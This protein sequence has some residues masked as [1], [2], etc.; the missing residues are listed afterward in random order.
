MQDYMQGD[1]HYLKYIY[2]KNQH[3]AE[4]SAYFLQYQ[5]ST[6]LTLITQIWDNVF[7]QKMSCR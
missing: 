7:H 1:A 2:F 4:D 6:K 5:S 3:G